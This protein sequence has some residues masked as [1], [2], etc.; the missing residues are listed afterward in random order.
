MFCD[1]DYILVTQHFQEPSILRQCPLWMV[2]SIP[3]I[4]LYRF[5]HIDEQKIANN[6]NNFLSAS[7]VLLRCA[8]LCDWPLFLYELS[9]ATNRVTTGL[10]FFCY[11]FISIII[12]LNLFIMVIIQNYEDFESNPEGCLSLFTK[13]EMKFKYVWEMNTKEYHGLKIHYKND[14]R[15]TINLSSDLQ[16]PKCL[17]IHLSVE[18]VIT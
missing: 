13:D 3:Y 5:H 7:L 12:I 14:F 16:I 18:Y 8:T 15:N 1:Y 11:M 10:F 2:N 4:L 17:E 6:F 9:A